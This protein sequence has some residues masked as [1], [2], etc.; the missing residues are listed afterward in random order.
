MVAYLQYVQILKETFAVFK[1][2][3]VPREQNARVDLLAKL[4]SSS[5]GG[6]QRT[7]IQETLRTP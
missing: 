2:V 1:L 7:M 6:R 5:K 4:A 3:Q